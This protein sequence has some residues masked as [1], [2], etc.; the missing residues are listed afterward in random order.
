M[1]YGIDEV[2]LGIDDVKLVDE[3]KYLCFHLSLIALTSASPC[4]GDIR[5]YAVSAIV[6]VLAASLSYGVSPCYGVPAHVMVLVHVL[7]LAVV[8]STAR[9]SIHHPTRRYPIQ[10][11]PSTHPLIAPRC[12]IHLRW[13]FLYHQSL[14]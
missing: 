12:Y 2:K 7:E 3:D 1:D 8:I 10:P 14:N 6:L 13:R 9:C 5:C 11:I 4:Y